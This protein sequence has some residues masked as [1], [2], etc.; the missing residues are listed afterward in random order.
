M[1]GLLATTDSKNRAVLQLREIVLYEVQVLLSDGT[2]TALVV[3]LSG[4]RATLDLGLPA[5]A[6]QPL[7]VHITRV[8]MCV[9]VSARACVCVCVCV[10]H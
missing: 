9:R 5:A 3:R 2:G 10:L 7:H 1:V 6:V 4:S 8:Y